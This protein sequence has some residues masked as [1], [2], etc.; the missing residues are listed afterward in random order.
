M[1][2]YKDLLEKKNGYFR[3][4]ERMSQGIL[5][6][7]AMGLSLIS[8]NIQKDK[9]FNMERFISIMKDLKDVKKKVK[10]YKN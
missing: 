9:D 2:T 7:A 5:Y 1:K 10:F 6:S 8:D 3:L 4:E